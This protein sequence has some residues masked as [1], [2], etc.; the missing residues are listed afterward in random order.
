MRPIL[1]TFVVVGLLLGSASLGSAADQNYIIENCDREQLWAEILKDIRWRAPEEAKFIEEHI[2]PTKNRPKLSQKDY[3][4]IDKMDKEIR[5]YASECI[6]LMKEI[7][8]FLGAIH[9]KNP[10]MGS[11]LAFTIDGTLVKFEIPFDRSFNRQ[12][13]L[14]P[15]FEFKY[16]LYM[17][18]GKL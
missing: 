18:F 1:M 14:K 6:L 16:Y 3:Q 17:P 10:N 9:S 5:W 4:D 13:N 11:R 7:N 8:E 15:F 12:N 2:Q